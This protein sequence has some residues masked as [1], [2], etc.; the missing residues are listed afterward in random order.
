MQIS[1]PR[2]ERKM[3]YL[4]ILK[5]AYQLYVRVWLAERG[6]L[7][8]TT[9]DTEKQFAEGKECYPTFAEFE[10]NEFQSEECMKRVFCD[11][12]QIYA[13]WTGRE[14]L[15]QLWL[16]QLLCNIHSL[17]LAG[18]FSLCPRCGGKMRK[19]L[20]YNCLSRRTTVYVCEPCGMHEAV[21][22]AAKA[23]NPG[24]VKKPLS[25][26]HIYANFVENIGHQL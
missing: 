26:W 7:H 12:P 19:K 14:R 6:C 18:D 5:L 24:F 8:P 9:F 2:K 13:Y 22:D 21:E 3:N 11:A 15:K 10:K 20:A 23:G 17:Q 4:S 1:S 16:E 25:E